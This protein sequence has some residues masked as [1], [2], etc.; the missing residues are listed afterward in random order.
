MFGSVHQLGVA[1]SRYN[2]AAVVPLGATE[3]GRVGGKDH[4]LGVGRAAEVRRK[5]LAARIVA[6][7]ALGDGASTLEQHSAAA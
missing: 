6:V 5:A 7:Q 3:S 1:G 2:S 4:A